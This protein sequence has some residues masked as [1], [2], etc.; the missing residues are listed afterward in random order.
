M[1]NLKRLALVSLTIY[2]VVGSLIIVFKSTNEQGQQRAVLA[3]AVTVNLSPL[4]QVNSG[5]AVSSPS[6]TAF[7]AM[8]VKAKQGDSRAACE[9]AVT[10]GKCIGRQGIDKASAVMAQALAP[11]G[12]A[13]GD[14]QIDTIV[15]MQETVEVSKEECSSIPAALKS[16]A[17]DYQ[18]LALGDG[19]D[20]RSILFNPLLDKQE[21]IKN[22]E[23]WQDYRNRS[24]AYVDRMLR[25]KNL[26][27][28]P[29]LLYVYAPEEISNLSPPF[30]LENNELFLSIYDV[31]VANG[32]QIPA[33][34]SSAAL[35][36][37][38]NKNNVTP[39]ELGGF[40]VD[41]ERGWH[42]NPPNMDAFS[43]N[44]YFSFDKRAEDCLLF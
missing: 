42:G 36:L 14:S 28:I 13:I 8:A 40:P 16:S 30:H 9:V 29:T 17:Y 11:L 22:L 43:T 23:R 1:A 37:R 2:C 10:L 21:F 26:D 6:G 19:F 32:S 3:Q 18:L 12:T 33:E 39:R 27:D 20:E 35:N 31:A 34:I 5:G 4:D 44:K 24:A 41:I 38:K 7:E 25:K 15:S